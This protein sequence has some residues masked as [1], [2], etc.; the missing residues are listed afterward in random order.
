MS[1]KMLYT[2]SLSIVCFVFQ[3][4]YNSSICTVIVRLMSL[5]H[6]PSNA[7]VLCTFNFLAVYCI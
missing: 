3:Q 7:I 5:S 6:A 1:K 4:E 2:S